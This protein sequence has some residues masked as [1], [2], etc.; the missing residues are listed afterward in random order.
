MT[1]RLIK[2]RFLSCGLS[3]APFLIGKIL[4]YSVLDWL[5]HL[6]AHDWDC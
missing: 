4:R 2:S 5:D 6:T 1:I 3:S